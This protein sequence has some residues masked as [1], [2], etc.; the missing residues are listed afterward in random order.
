VRRIPLMSDGEIR[1]SND[2]FYPPLGDR[3][4]SEVFDLKPTSA[5]LSAYS[6]AYNRQYKYC[7]STAEYNLDIA[8]GV[9]PEETGEHSALSDP[10]LV[11]GSITLMGAGP[12]NRENGGPDRCARIQ[13]LT[14]SESN[15]LHQTSRDERLVSTLVTILT[16]SSPRNEDSTVRQRRTVDSGRC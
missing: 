12:E 9:Q 1:I 4:T 3:I 2:R 10:V 8:I 6:W 5:R 15:H 7:G 11:I 13:N 16:L 14:L